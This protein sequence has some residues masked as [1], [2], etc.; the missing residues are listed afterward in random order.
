MNT[1]PHGWVGSGWYLMGVDSAHQ[2][3]SSMSLQIAD[4]LS[5]L[6]KIYHIVIDIGLCN[7]L[8]SEA[9]S[10]V[11]KVGKWL[12]GYNFLSDKCKF[13]TEN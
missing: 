9:A 1:L 6:Q 3:S 10:W 7:Q 2:A 11:K 13:L 4:D 12:G 5:T 8:H